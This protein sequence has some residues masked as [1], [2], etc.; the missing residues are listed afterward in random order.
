ME[1]DELFFSSPAVGCLAVSAVSFAEGEA[2]WLP[3]LGCIQFKLPA[4]VAKKNLQIEKI[5]YC[6]V[7]KIYFRGAKLLNYNTKLTS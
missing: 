7:S 4:F 3:F 1:S 2:P 6:I 5:F